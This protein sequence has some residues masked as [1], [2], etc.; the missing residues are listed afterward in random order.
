MATPTV[1]ERGHAYRHLHTFCPNLPSTLD[2]I[3]WEFGVCVISFACARYGR[4][5]DQWGW[6]DEIEVGVLQEFHIWM[7]E[8]RMYVRIGEDGP[9]LMNGVRPENQN[10][11][12]SP[13]LHGRLELGMLFDEDV[14][15]DR[16]GLTAIYDWAELI[17]N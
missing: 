8:E 11:I 3:N 14:N 4:G 17:I 15:I 2:S 1:V 5:D 9:W 12:V 10:A 6:S 13:K 7:E 16:Q